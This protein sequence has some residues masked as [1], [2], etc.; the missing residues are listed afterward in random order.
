MR[1]SVAQASM[2]VF[3]TG[4]GPPA[5]PGGP[6]RAPLRYSCRSLATEIQ[7]FAASPPRKTHTAA[8]NNPWSVRPAMRASIA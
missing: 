7:V 1:A 8:R 4:I 5:T 2:E 6:Q 3:Q